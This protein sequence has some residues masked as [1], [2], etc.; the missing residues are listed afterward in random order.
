MFTIGAFCLQ[1]EFCL[2]IGALLLT[3]GVLLLTVGLMLLVET[4]MDSKQPNSTAS[5]T[6]PTVHPHRN[7]YKLIASSNLICNSV[8]NMFTQLWTV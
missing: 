2:T 4:S 7:Y 8:C 5:K 1:L 6:A 3:I